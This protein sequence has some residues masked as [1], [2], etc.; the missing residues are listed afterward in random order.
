MGDLES[1]RWRCLFTNLF[2]KSSNPQ[3]LLT[4][5]FRD[6]EGNRRAR[7]VAV[8]QTGRG[9]IQMVRED[10]GGILTEQRDYGIP[11]GD[12]GASGQRD[13]CLSVAQQTC[14]T[15]KDQKEAETRGS[16]GG[17]LINVCVHFFIFTSVF[18]ISAC[19]VQS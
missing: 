19:Y 15:V 5:R 4:V 1:T 2:L 10:D 3:P 8:I 6:A 12:D 7:F 11:R 18:H 14:R 16:S 13:G 9:R 17:G